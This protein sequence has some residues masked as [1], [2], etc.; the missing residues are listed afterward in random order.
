MRKDNLSFSGLLDLSRPPRWWFMLLLGALLWGG[1]YVRRDLWSPDEARYAL[2]SK[3]MRDGHWLVPFRQGEFYSHKPPLMFWLTNLFSVVTG[4]EIGNVAPRLPS[5][6]GAMMALWAL[7][8][9][10]ARWFS[11]RAAWVT[12]LLVPSTF[13]FWNKGGFGQIDMLLCG[14][15]MMALYFLFTSNGLR[16]PGRLAAAYAF[17]G[18]A[19]LAKG[20]VG[21]LVPLG[22]YIAGTLASGERFARP[23]SHWV[24]GTL[25]AMAFPAAWLGAAWLQGAPDGFFDEILFKQNVG[26][27][28][29]EFGGHNKP[30][31]YFLQYLP[32]DL[33]PWTFMFPV[34][35]LALKRFPEYAPGRRRLLAWMLFVVLFFSLSS[36]K[37]NL[38]IMLV[39]PAGAMFI[40][41]ATDAWVCAHEKWLKRSFWATWGF[42]VLL[43]GMLAV[44]SFVPQVPF[45][46]IFLLP[47]GVVMLAGAWWTRAVF[48]RGPE[49]PAWLAAL[50]VTFL[51]GYAFIGT[52]GY[53]ELDDLKTPDEIIAVAQAQ[54]EPDERLITYDWHGEIVSLYADRLGFMADNQQELAEFLVNTTQSNHLVVCYPKH[55]PAVEEVIGS[56]HTSGS[57]T[58]GSKEV[59]W[60]TFTTAEARPTVQSFLGSGE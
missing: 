56:G 53:G 59:V 44:G 35:W 58:T 50:A 38:Y 43:G 25:I 33:L 7:T 30:F 3:E 12:L 2:V 54:L 5:F 29:G 37:R 9:L 15:E 24:W 49:R 60:R 14:L 55:L 46:A 22:V 47:A 17:M 10:A 19:I 11:V 1:E 27:V 31:Y 21:F 52:L 20:P 13:L 48:R 41:A 39:Y 16:A 32:I 4:G 40:A 45:R 18:L 28:A 26:R 34:S 6:L 8:R 42:L 57:F 36:S 23:A 51:A